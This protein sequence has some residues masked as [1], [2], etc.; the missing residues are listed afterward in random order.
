MVCIPY[1][2]YSTLDTVRFFKVLT[3]FWRVDSTKSG[4]RTISFHFSPYINFYMQS[5]ADD[6]TVVTV[7]F[8]L[9]N[10]IFFQNTVKPEAVHCLG[11]KQFPRVR[12]MNFYRDIVSLIF[13]IFS[14]QFKIV[15]LILMLS[16][17]LLPRQQCHYVPYFERR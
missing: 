1:R 4:M 6:E 9:L 7:N 8:I 5:R 16:F 17:L 12:L 3:L 11:L 15:F 2:L 14:I 13:H 10:H